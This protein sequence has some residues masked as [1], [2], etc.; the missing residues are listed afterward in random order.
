MSS[1]EESKFAGL[2]ASDT[3]FA[4]GISWFQISRLITMSMTSRKPAVDLCR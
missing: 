1:I 3:L 2:N 4:W